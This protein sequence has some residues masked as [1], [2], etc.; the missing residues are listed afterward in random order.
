MRRTFV[1]DCSQLPD[2]L[3]LVMLD[4]A[5]QPLPLVRRG[6]IAP[7]SA[8]VPM[9][10]PP[11]LPGHD[12]RGAIRAHPA[13]AFARGRE[14]VSWQTSAQKSPRRILPRALLCGF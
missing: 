4:P 3:S 1:F 12:E 13:L 8:I 6:G 5:T 7:S 11:P 10:N 14:D 9:I 2:C